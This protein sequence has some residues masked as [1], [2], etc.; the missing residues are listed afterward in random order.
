MFVEVDG[1]KYPVQIEFDEEVGLY[2]ALAT[3]I[4]VCSQ[5]KTVEEALDNLREA[6][7]LYLEDCE[8]LGIK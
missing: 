7:E 2:S 1:V 6:I 4:E 8:A 3:T 5:G